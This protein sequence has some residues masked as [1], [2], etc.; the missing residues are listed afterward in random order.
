[1]LL[2]TTLT[3]SAD[4]SNRM[5]TTEFEVNA[6]I[7][8]VWATWTTPNGIKTFFAPEYAT[9]LVRLALVCQLL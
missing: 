9:H 8:K 6:P 5:L 4:A 7:E 1:V 3:L 2:I